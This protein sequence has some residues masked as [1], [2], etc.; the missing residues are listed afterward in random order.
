MKSLAKLTAC[1]LSVY[2]LMSSAVFAAGDVSVVSMRGYNANGGTLNKILSSLKGIEFEINTNA[3]K[4]ISLIV[5]KYSQN[6]CKEVIISDAVV[7][8]E[9]ENGK[10][11]VPTGSISGIDTLKCIVVEADEDGL[12]P[13]IKEVNVF[14]KQGWSEDK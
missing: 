7:I 8:N 14:T 12:Y 1:V 11:T 13:I 6:I 4:T 5:A 10:V 9:T 3:D 2:L